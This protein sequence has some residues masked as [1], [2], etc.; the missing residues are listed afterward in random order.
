MP[1]ERAHMSNDPLAGLPD[2]P[3][4]QLRSTDVAHGEPLPLAQRSFLFGAEG[5]RDLSPQLSWT[6][7]PRKTKSFVVTMYDPDAPTGAGFWHWAIADIPA[8]ST[9][10]ATG[11]GAESGALLPRRAFHLPNDVGI[12]GYVGG[13]PAAG[14]G[15][16]RY[17]FVVHALDVHQIKVA[18]TAT[19]SY[20]GLH[21]V[22]H[23]IGRAVLIATASDN[24]PRSILATA[25]H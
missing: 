21:L 23:V 1:A 16:H 8:D 15:E 22:H 25:P 10:L 6:L 20:L 18:P 4:F 17:Y 12:R 7:A 24:M 9:E 5:G 3:A 14:S 2:V 11:A 19:P 13:S